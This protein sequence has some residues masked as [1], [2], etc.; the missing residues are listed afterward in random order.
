MFYILF[1]HR[2]LVH[3]SQRTMWGSVITLQLDFIWICN[4]D[5]NS[6]SKWLPESIMEFY[7]LSSETLMVVEWSYGA[8]LQCVIFVPIWNSRRLRPQD[9]DLLLAPYGKK[10]LSTNF[11]KTRWMI[12]GWSFTKLTW[13]RHPSFNIEPYEK[14]NNISEKPQ[15][16][17]DTI[18]SW[19]IIRWAL[20]T[21]WEFLC[22]LEIQDDHNSKHSLTWDALVKIF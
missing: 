10:Y 17:L 9:K 14:I 13:I 22:G 11:T 15:T 6:N 5:A 12:M 8:S 7:W 3:F 20:T 19:M 2:F 1:H 4:F 16:W 18:C 21:N